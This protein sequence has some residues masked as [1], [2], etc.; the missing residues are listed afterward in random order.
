MIK[1][2]GFKSKT[3]EA[4][5][6]ANELLRKNEEPTPELDRDDTEHVPGQ[7]WHPLMNGTGYKTKKEKADAGRGKSHTADKKSTQDTKGNN[8]KE[9]K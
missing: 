1:E 6:K 7:P 4:A 8:M 2:G 9:T 3:A 5:R